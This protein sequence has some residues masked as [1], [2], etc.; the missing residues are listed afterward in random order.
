M[1]NVSDAFL[2]VLAL[3]ASSTS[4]PATRSNTKQQMY[5]SG[6]RT[7]YCPR[8]GLWHE[9]RSRT[10]VLAAAADEDTALDRVTDVLLGVLNDGP[11][12]RSGI[13]R[14]IGTLP[15]TQ[16]AFRKISD[17]APVLLTRHYRPVGLREPI[18]VVIEEGRL[19][20]Q[21]AIEASAKGRFCG[22]LLLVAPGTQTGGRL[23]AKIE[24]T[25]GRCATCVYR[26]VEGALNR[27][28][29]LP[30]PLKNKIRLGRPV[31]SLASWH[32]LV[33]PSSDGI[34]KIMCWYL[35]A[36]DPETVRSATA[37]LLRERS[38]APTR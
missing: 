6:A 33:R 11:E 38:P 3:G 1:E 2:E 32:R 28:M 23:V 25:R 5:V 10:T 31:E 9:T 22:G 26:S 12:R 35:G 16:E 7:L 21:I 20:M 14:T 8:P 29:L 13:E 34:E 4:R 30:E 15:I 37:I 36:P 27:S 18:D 24:T 19:R 17:Q